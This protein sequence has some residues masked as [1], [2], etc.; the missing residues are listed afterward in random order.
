M[1][2]QTHELTKSFGEVHAL[3]NVSLKVQQG[4]ICGLLGPN[5]AGKST[6][7][8]LLMGFMRPT[9]GWAQI[10]KL[11]CYSQ[12][13]QVHARVSYLPGDARLF[14]G[15]QGKAALKFFA[16]VRPQGNY[17]RSLHLAERL[18][19]D[20]GR[21]VAYMSTG[22]R[23]K[24]ALAA[25]LAFDTPL[26]ILDEPTAN[27]DP[28]V[29]SEILAL[30]AEAGAAGR[31]VIFS[32][33]VLSE[34]EEICDRV[35]ILKQGKLVHSQSMAEIK[36]RHQIKAQTANRLP[37]PPAELKANLGVTHPTADTVIIETPT[38]LS[39]LLGWLSTL[40]L[41]EMTIE[42]VGLRRVYEQYHPVAKAKPKT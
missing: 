14:D 26:L 40:D 5:G 10:D 38:E 30:V 27:L 3:N 19:L 42:Q 29:R 1:L 28:T 7:L 35:V 2:V 16:T 23:Q 21:K 18:E 39:P 25:V 8:R 31:T 4:E 15:M 37:E 24:L 9:A 6:L 17:E 20:L 36:R 13:V 32:S 34:V 22:M 41:K 12:R 11:D 33:H